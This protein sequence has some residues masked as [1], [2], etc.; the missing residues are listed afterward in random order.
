MPRLQVEPGGAE[1]LG[2]RLTQVNE[3]EQAVL[4]EAITPSDR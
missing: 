4:S 2:E 3:A 1:G